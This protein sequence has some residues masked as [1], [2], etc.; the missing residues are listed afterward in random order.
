MTQRNYREVG[1]CVIIDKQ[2]R[3]LLLLRSKTDRWKPGWW[4]LPGGHLDGDETP[5][6]GATREAFEECSLVVRGLIKI[7][8]YKIATQSQHQSSIQTFGCF[9]CILPKSRWFYVVIIL[10]VIILIV[11]FIYTRKRLTHTQTELA[12]CR[13]NCRS[14]I[15]NI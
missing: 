11:L 8:G 6:Q 10:F 9:K 13:S 15:S 7:E 12:S 1:S 3:I 4:D 5:M 2:N 14:E